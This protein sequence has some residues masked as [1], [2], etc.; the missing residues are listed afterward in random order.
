MFAENE[1][2]NLGAIG[3]IQ[4]R[5]W[6][7]VRHPFVGGIELTPYCNLK[8]VHCY[9]QDFEKS[10][11]LSTVQI[12][13]IIDKIYDAG[14]LFL[15]FT[16][17][18]IFT[19]KDFLDVYIYAKKKGFIIELLT[20]GSLIDDTAI[21]VFNKYPPAS[22]SISMYGKDENSYKRVTGMDGIYEK[23]I[24]TFD[25][26]AKNQI[27]F[28]IKYIGMK[29]NEDDFFEVKKI[30]EKYGAAFSYAMELFP[31]LKGNSCTKKHM[32]ELEKI[33]EI[34]SEYDVKRKEIEYQAKI[35]NPFGDREEVPLYLCD[36]AVSNFLIDYRGYIN[37]CHKCRIEKWNLL[38]VD[39]KT[40]WDDFGNIR[41]IRTASYNKCIKCKYVMMCSPC[42][43]V[44][45]LSTGDYNVPPDTVCKLTHMRVKMIEDCS[46]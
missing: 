30:A 31:T 39:L 2:F 23:V 24:H 35:E 42:V 17:G 41:K 7:K 15:Y 1:N 5:K 26:L 40:A 43:L 20:N 38:T 33:I 4:E 37:P 11:L 14:V 21:G 3:D 10:V 29:E 46:K 16:G 8:C 19:R 22:V 25:M 27:H 12:K 28:E 18:E 6:N 44:N 45:Y 13:K 34:E 9:L 36:M 32:M